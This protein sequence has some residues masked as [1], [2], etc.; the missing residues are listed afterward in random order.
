MTY[1]M[2][3]FPFIAKFLMKTMAI[4]VYEFENEWL[5]E[6]DSHVCFKPIFCIDM[7]MNSFVGF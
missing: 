2:K 4:S 1:L 6:G 3:K 5:G 7:E